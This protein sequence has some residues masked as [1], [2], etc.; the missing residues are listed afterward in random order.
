MDVFYRV[1]SPGA[2]WRGQEGLQRAPT[3]LLWI[4]RVVN[5]RCEPARLPF[6]QVPTMLGWPVRLHLCRMPTWYSECKGRKG[7]YHFRHQFRRGRGAFE[8]GGDVHSVM[9]DKR[10]ELMTDYEKSVPFNGE[11][12]K[13]VE[14]ARSVFFQ[15]SFRIVSNEASAVEFWG[16]GTIWVKG[17]DPL[18]GISKV[19]IEAGH[20]KV[21]IRADFGGTRKTI[22]YAAFFL[23]SLALFFV[24]FFGILFGVRGEPVMNI[25]LFSLVPFA[26]WPVIL[27]LMAKW[28]KSRT[29]RALVAVGNEV[30]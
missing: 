18:A 5:G 20:D 7:H 10:E 29:S 27:P 3:G 17:Q 24:V 14:L 1:I 13:S 11:A 12:S 4:C 15:H 22:K 30:Q 28:M 21:S 23:V 2:L 6:R 26:P 16:P 8:G 25:I 9:I 19:S